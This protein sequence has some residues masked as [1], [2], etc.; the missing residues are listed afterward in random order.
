MNKLSDIYLSEH[1]DIEKVFI[2]TAI[3]TGTRASDF[4]ISFTDYQITGNIG[5]KFK[6]KLFKRSTEFE[7]ILGLQKVL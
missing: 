7:E 4:N 2:K 3:T 5:L 6:K 1:C